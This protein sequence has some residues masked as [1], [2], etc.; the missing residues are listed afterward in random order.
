MIQK[1]V[2]GIVDF[3]RLWCD[4]LDGFGDLLGRVFVLLFFFLLFGMT[5][6]YCTSVGQIISKNSISSLSNY[7]L[8][9][10]TT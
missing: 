5:P 10:H 1:R 9:I 7:L 3:Q 8:F 4:Y 2:D 6:V